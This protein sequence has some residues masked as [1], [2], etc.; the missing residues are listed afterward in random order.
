MAKWNKRRVNHNDVEV[1][2]ANFALTFAK[3]LLVFCVMMFVL[4]APNQ[5]ANDGVRPKVE[6]MILVDWPRDAKTDIDTWVKTNQGQ[7]V[8]FGNKEAGNVFL[9]RDDLGQE[10]IEVCEEIVSIR[11][12]DPG[13]FIINLNVFG[14]RQKGAIQNTTGLELNPP[15]PVHIKIVKMN[16]EIKIVWEQDVILHYVKE[17]LP[18]VRF[19]ILDKE[20]TDI[21]SDQPS[22]L[23]NKIDKKN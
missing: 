11:S 8:Y 18:V 16:P 9:D 13:E 6:V 4:I 2:L 1:A 15:V 14:T 3:A 23:M 22:Y 5:N 7:I 19:S 10:C 20:I 17:E 12:L 21:H